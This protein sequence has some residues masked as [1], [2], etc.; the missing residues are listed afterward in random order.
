MFWTKSKKI[1][2]S[3]ITLTILIVAL[4]L[5]YLLSPSSFP[6]FKPITEQ[7]ILSNEDYIEDFDY[8]YSI[9]ETYYPFFEINKIAN[10]VDWIGN[11]EEYKSL[12]SKCNTDEEFYETMGLIL[13]ELNNGHTHLLDPNY[14]LDSY[15]LYK[16]ISPRI[17]WRADMV[18]IFEKPNVQ[19][20]HNITNERIDDMVE[21]ME[22]YVPD[23]SSLKNIVV[24]DIVPEKVG[25]ISIK[26][27]ITPDLN[28]P[29]FKEEHDII[30]KYLEEVMDYS[31]LIIDI[32]ENGGGN[33]A[34][35]SDF[36]MPL[37]VDKTYSQDTYSF[38]KDG[39]LLNRFRKQSGF[40]EL[41]DDK[42]SDF[43]FP[44]NTNNIIKDYSYYMNNTF[45]V[46]PSK[47]SINFGGNLYLLVDRYV[48]S[49]SEKLASFAKE[50]EMAVLVG[51]RTGG[52]GIGTDPMLIDLPNTGYVLRF[53][54]EL[55]I[56]EQGG[57]NELD[58]TEPD[59]L[60]PNPRKVTSRNG[61]IVG[62]DEA[63]STILEMEGIFID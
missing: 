43:N 1:I 23:V 36:L 6:T 28:I 7:E 61:P 53:S 35:W 44:Q 25:Y 37:I 11:R 59:I 27:M 22:N 50:S 57:I 19:A 26:Q 16:M 9:L 17:D 18:K 45:D 30:K 55:G 29:S 32:R 34:Y 39:P 12:I 58:Q 33:S 56:T 31:V 38:V 54:K 20:R 48:Y 5:N 10:N 21:H 8:A 15:V 24:A 14:G 40:K 47:D 42:I 4:V 13:A 46:I 49:S 60:I 62:Y 52:D 2:I 3:A 63:I 41:T 51:E